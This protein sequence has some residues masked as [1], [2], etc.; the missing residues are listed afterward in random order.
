MNA[1]DPTKSATSTS[2]ADWIKRTDV[3]WFPSMEWSHRNVGA[4]LH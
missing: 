3:R 4:A 1:T 2:L